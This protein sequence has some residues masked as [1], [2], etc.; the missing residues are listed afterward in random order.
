MTPYL[1]IIYSCFLNPTLSQRKKTMTQL[2]LLG[3]SKR[4]DFFIYYFFNHLIMSR[5]YSIM[6]RCDPINASGMYISSS[7]QQ[8]LDQFRI[9]PNRSLMER[10]PAWQVK[11]MLFTVALNY[12][13]DEQAS[14]LRVSA[15][16]NLRNPPCWHWS[17]PVWAPWLVLDRLSYRPCVE[18]SPPF[19]FSCSAVLCWEFS[20]VVWLLFLT[21]YI[22]HGL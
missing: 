9:I 2:F 17:Q 3:C 8:L 22:K 12:I 15:L 14:M 6:E 19:H 21:G 4:S 11:S 16:T 1:L 20:H 18:E 10:C 5:C 7:L 13:H